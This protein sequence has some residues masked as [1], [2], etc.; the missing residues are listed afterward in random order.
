MKFSEFYYVS[1]MLS[2]IFLKTNKSRK[3]K[4]FYKLF[5]KKKESK[6]KDINKLNK[7]FLNQQEKKIVLKQ[8][9]SVSTL[10]S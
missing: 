3:E 4:P 9:S 1:T 6:G 10:L 7:W 2:I 8:D 5:K